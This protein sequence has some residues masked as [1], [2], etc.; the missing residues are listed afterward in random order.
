MIVFSTN[1]VDYLNREWDAW[2][3]KYF[4]MCSVMRRRQI[5]TPILRHWLSCAYSDFI[6]IQLQ[7]IIYG[8]ILIYPFS[9]GQ[10]AF[11]DSKM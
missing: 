11:I 5:L 4:K 10:R 7:L 2:H 1:N 8:G 3:Q 6:D 9:N